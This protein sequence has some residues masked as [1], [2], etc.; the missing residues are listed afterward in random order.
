MSHVRDSII[1]SQGT[2]TFIKEPWTCLSKRLWP[3]SMAHI[4]IRGII[5]VFANGDKSLNF[6]IREDCK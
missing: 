3:W 4:I 5:T 6:T 1:S 2:V